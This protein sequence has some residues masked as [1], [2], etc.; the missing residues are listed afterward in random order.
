[1]SQDLAAQ[2]PAWIQMLSERVDVDA[3]A[4]KAGETPCR[5]TLMLVGLGTLLF[6]ASERQGNEKVGDMWDALEYCTSSL[7]VGYTDVY[8]QTPLG[9]A[10]GSALM[11]FGP[12]LVT[13]MTDPLEARRPNPAQEE[14]LAT[15]REILAELKKRGTAEGTMDERG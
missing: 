1:M 9:K 6:Y 15:L 2:L 7:N 3:W 4:A 8:P 10:V 12:S 11:L 13:R 14:M 5:T